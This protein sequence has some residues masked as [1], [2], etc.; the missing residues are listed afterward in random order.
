MQLLPGDREEAELCVDGLVLVKELARRIKGYGGAVLIADY[1][2]EA[3]TELTLR[4]GITTT[5][6]SY[7]Q[8][9]LAHTHSGIPEAPAM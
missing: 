8:S 1:G 4:V 6:Y 9:T 5:V 2:E 7:N 3:V